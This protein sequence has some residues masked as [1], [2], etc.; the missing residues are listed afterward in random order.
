MADFIDIAETSTWLINRALRSTSDS[1]DFV[2]L[3]VKTP[4][5]A[6]HIAPAN[7]N[8]L[9]SLVN[10]GS[11]YTTT[12]TSP[13]LSQSAEVELYLLATNF[14]VCFLVSFSCRDLVS[15]RSINSFLLLLD[16]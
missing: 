8:I 10:D 15:L 13:F 12:S 2:N 7:D 4:S 5:S 6:A 9:D 16:Q 1:D 11:S 14:L 3:E